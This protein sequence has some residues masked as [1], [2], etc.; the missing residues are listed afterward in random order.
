MSTT[1]QAALATPPMQMI[2]TW[3][4]GIR[5]EAAIKKATDPTPSTGNPVMSA[6]DGTQPAKE[7]E[8]GRENDADVKAELGENANVGE[9]PVNSD[10]AGAKPTD[11]IGT[12]KQD[13]D[14]VVGNVPTP[15]AAPDST[16]ATV[17][18]EPKSASLARQGKGLLSLFEAAPKQASAQAD[19]G[20]APIKTT[21]PAVAANA[22]PAGDKQTPPEKV[23][24]DMATKRASADKH[25]DYAEMGYAAATEFLTEIGLIQPQVDT[26]KQAAIEKVANVMKAAEE[27]ADMTCDFLDN[28]AN[29][30]RIATLSKKAEP[31]IAAMTGAV[32]PE[33]PGAG[34]PPVG[35]ADMGGGA[36]PPDMM[37]GGDPMAGAGGPPGTGGGAGGPPGMGGPG[38]GGENEQV[39][40]AIAQALDSGQVTAQDLI[41]ALEATMGGGG[42]APGGDAMGGGGPPPAA[43]GGEGP[44]K[45]EGGGGDSKPKETPEKKET[46]KEEK[47]DTGEDGGKEAALRK[48]AAYTLAGAILGG[49]KAKQQNK[50]ASIAAFVRTKLSR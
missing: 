48:K 23:V 32:S 34:A 45:A 39:L 28:Y 30:V 18:G 25:R 40:D 35:G 44:P 19:E 17:F 31:E 26:V 24:D 29:G 5:K 2:N 36:I 33:G 38:G 16:M 49:F 46:D 8:R 14:K 11:T 4:T 3:L 20:G 37:G 27:A 41:G 13:A 10:T 42:G 9:T 12:Q 43:G 15:K 21:T 50:A 6:P 1:K 47:A 7:G 22:A